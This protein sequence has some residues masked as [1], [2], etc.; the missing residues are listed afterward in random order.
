MLFRYIM[1]VSTFD[2]VTEVSD[3]AN[4]LKAAVKLL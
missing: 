4:V 1:V 3:K 2:W